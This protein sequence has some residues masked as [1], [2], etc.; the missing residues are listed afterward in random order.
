[1][2][3]DDKQAVGDDWTQSPQRDRRLATA[4]A[5]GAYGHSVE[6]IHER[7]TVRRFSAASATSC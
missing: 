6:Q 5:G 7:C 1:M 3:V 4:L 2:G